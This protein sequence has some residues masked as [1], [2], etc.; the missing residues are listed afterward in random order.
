MGSAP[1]AGE[2]GG[3]LAA[4]RQTAATLIATARTRIELAG[5]ELASERLRLVRLLVLGLSAL[6]C[7]AFGVLLLAGL[8]LA[9]YWESRIAVLGGLAAVFLVAGA[10][11][12][13]AMNRANRRHQAFAATIAELE[14]DVRQLRAATGHAKSPD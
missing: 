1:G 3:L 4:L 6:F 12:Y 11:L 8:L 7:L 2:A 5:N 10:L 13:V 9:I 14:E